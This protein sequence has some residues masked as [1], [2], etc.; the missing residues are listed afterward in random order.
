MDIDSKNAERIFQVF[1]RLHAR[2]TYPGTGIGLAICKKIVEQHGGRIWVDSRP[3][4]GAIFYF[5][6]SDIKRRGKT[7]F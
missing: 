1:Q 3:T 4:E 2:N 5:T 7:A 6:I